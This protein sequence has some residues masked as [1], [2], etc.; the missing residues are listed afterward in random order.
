MAR[1]SGLVTCWICQGTEASQVANLH[2]KTPRAFGGDDSPDNLVW[3]C[4]SHH[5]LLHR[6]AEHLVKGRVGRACDLADITFPSSPGSR[7]RVFNLAQAAAK[8]QQSHE[9]SVGDITP[10][11]VNITL[12]PDLY[13][14]LKARSIDRG[15]P[16]SRYLVRILENSL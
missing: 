16:L 5:N 14:E 8:A 15:V 7:Q 3:L 1:N 13:I 9:E 4:S 10:K 11:K 2:H 12:E 6:M